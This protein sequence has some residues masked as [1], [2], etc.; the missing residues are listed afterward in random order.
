[1]LRRFLHLRFTAFLIGWIFT[2]MSF[3]IPVK[4]LR[5]TPNLVA[6][7]HPSPGHKF[8][9]LIVP[10]R[11]IQSLADLDP[12]DTALLTDLYSTVQSLVKE[13]EL[14]AYR[15]I[16]NGGEYQD[17]PHLHFHLISNL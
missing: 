7:Q 6:F 17:F 12:H 15:L 16:V 5:E 2:Y 10:K 9:L 1:M 4:R 11:Q 3:A 13:F 8:H 14:K